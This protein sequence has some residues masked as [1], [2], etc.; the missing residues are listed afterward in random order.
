LISRERDLENFG[1]ASLNEVRFFFC[2]VCVTEFEGSGGFFFAAP[3]C[4]YPRMC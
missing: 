2:L 1:S 4:A 3:T